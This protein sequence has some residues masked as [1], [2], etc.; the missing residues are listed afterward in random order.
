MVLHAGSCDPFE[1][2]SVD[3]TVPWERWSS[4]AEAVVASGSALILVDAGAPSAAVAA[5]LRA[6][7][8]AVVDVDDVKR[9]LDVVEDLARERLRAEDLRCLQPSQFRRDQLERLSELS[10]K[11]TRVLFYLT[12]GYTAERIASTQWTS[13]STV[14][15]HI[16]SIFRKLDVNSQIAAVALANGT[17]ATDLAGTEE[18]RWSG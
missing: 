16:R 6:G 17:A 14:R 1:R 18:I 3:F 9:V 7:A 15:A 2:D 4:A 5:C 13:V 12:C 8:L 11:E 10:T